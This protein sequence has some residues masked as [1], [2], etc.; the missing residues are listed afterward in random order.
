MGQQVLGTGRSGAP[1]RRRTASSEPLQKM[2]FQL[3][4]SVAEAIRAVVNA[5]EAP[6]ANVFV[7]EAVK[8]ALRERRRK[9]VY[10]AYAEAAQDEAFMAEMVETEHAFRSTLADGAQ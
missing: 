10:A 5:G 4:T 8:L 3:H 7:E 9:R 2:S 1:R 6:S